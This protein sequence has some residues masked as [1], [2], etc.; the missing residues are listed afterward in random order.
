MWLIIIVSSIFVGFGHVIY[1]QPRHKLDY[2]TP[3][4]G[5][6]FILVGILLAVG[7]LIAQFV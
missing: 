1:N 7:G 4:C 5:L 2:G 6:I 3:L